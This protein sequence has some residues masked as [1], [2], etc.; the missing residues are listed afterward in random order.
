MVNRLARFG[1]AVFNAVDQFIK[2]F[3]RH[4]VLH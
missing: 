4:P 2:I 3:N 1:I